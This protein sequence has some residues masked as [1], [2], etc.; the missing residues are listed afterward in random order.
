[1]HA[2]SYNHMKTIDL[3]AAM[4]LFI[5]GVNW[6]LVGLL[7]VNL[8]TSIFSEMSLLSRLVYVIVGLSALYDA[9]MWKAI[10]RRWECSGFMRE[11]ESPAV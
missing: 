9:V 1:M 2:K 3:I 5:G 10:Q 11:A 4:F 7:D 8:I 6:G